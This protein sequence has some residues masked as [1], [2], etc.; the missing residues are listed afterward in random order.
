MQVRQLDLKTDKDDVLLGIKDFISRMTFKDFLPTD[1][2]EL[3]FRALELLN[4]DFVKTVV[5]VH[6]GKIVAGLGLAFVPCMWNEKVIQVDEI[7]WW[8]SPDAPNSAALHVLKYA[9]EM[10]EFVKESGLAEKVLVSFKKLTS[11]PEK[12]AKVYKRMGMVE[13]ETSYMRIL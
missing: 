2:S 6:D 13:V 3:N 5:A 7:F 10:T 4:K 8:S 9:T 12:V 11:S 1:E